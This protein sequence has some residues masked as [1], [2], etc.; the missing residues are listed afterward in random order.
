MLKGSTPAELGGGSL[1]RETFFMRGRIEGN[2]WYRW[3]VVLLLMP[4][5]LKGAE[6]TVKEVM[7]KLHKGPNAPVTLIKKK[8]Q[9]P[10]PNWDDV[11]R[12]TKEVVSLAPELAKNDPPKGAKTSWEK[13]ATQYLTNA[14]A[15]DDSAKLKDRT[16]TLGARDKL[17]SSCSAC[18]RAHK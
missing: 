1:F 7:A 8:L 14:R 18:H 3:G 2:A 6:Y 17:A 9:K 13:L 5:S 4:Q 11:Q 15:L 10:E 16:A 12:L